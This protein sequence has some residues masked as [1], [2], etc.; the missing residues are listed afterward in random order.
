VEAEPV[1][2]TEVEIDEQVEY[3]RDRFSSLEPVDDRGVE[4][5]D[6]AL[7][8]F[9]STI[10][11][12]P[13]ENNEVDGLLYELGRGQ[14]PQ[15]FDD[16][17]LGAHA[18]DERV[19]EF[20]IPETSSQPEYV[21]KTVRFELRVSEVKAKVLPDVD[22]EFAASVGGFES[23]DQLRED[24]RTRIE[25]TRETARLRRV[26]QEGRKALAERL[27]G[28]VP[29]ELLAAKKEEMLGELQTQLM[30]RQMT[31]ESYME[32]SGTTEEEIETDVAREAAAR[33]REELA[34]EA[35]FVAKGLE[36][37][38]G[39]MDI[40]V[41]A[42][43]ERYEMDPDTLRVTLRDRLM[44]PD[45]RQ[46]LMQRHA[47]G[48]L[49]DNVEVKEVAAIADPSADNAEKPAAGTPSGKKKAAA[50]EADEEN[51]V[52][53]PAAGEEPADA[54]EVEAEAEAA[55]PPE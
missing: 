2:A 16:A 53:E 1:K 52:P 26:E 33:L 45:V 6:F 28:E 47:T 54:P 40:E 4:P 36:I 12:E 15:E 48:W 9:T 32:Q 13:Y 27:E 10:D 22:E 30:Q 8:S 18:G 38:E 14:M 42:M 17:L 25:Q 37:G 21:G 11:G 29:D 7:I 23:V 35:L 51:A 5:G 20:V 41:A 24:V 50:D 39:E 49:M 31:L 34:L 46:R 55:A 43:A 19:S 3:L 44:L